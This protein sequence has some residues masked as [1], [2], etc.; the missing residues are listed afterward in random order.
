MR[1]ADG[2]RAAVVGFADQYGLAARLASSGQ[3]S[4]RLSGFELPTRPQTWPTTFSSSLARRGTPCK[5]SGLNT[6]A[7]SRG[8]R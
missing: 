5:S 4:R 3:S 2:E 1:P 6:P 8:V 7:C